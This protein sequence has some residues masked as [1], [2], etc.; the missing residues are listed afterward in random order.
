MAPATSL[1]VMGFLAGS[2]IRA[3]LL[4]KFITLLLPPPWRAMTKYHSSMLTPMISKKGMNSIYQGVTMG[5]R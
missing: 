4:P 5:G 2:L 3:R 1:K